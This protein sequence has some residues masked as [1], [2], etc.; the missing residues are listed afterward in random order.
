MKKL[1]ILKEKELYADKAYASKKHDQ[2]LKRKG[3]VNRILHKGKRNH[4]LSDKQKDQNKQWSSIRSTVERVFGVL[5]LHHGIRKARYLGLEGNK[6]SFVLTATA[7]NIK[8]GANIKAG[9]Y[10]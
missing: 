7:H 10:V 5:K 8:R 1:L 3:I 2:G 4:P 9:I 6:T